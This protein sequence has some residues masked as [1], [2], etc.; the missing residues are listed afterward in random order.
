MDAFAKERLVNVLEA[1]HVHRQQRLISRRRTHP[2]SFID[3]QHIATA[4][5]S[6]CVVAPQ[7]TRHRIGS[8]KRRPTSSFYEP[9]R[10]SIRTSTS[11][12]CVYSHLNIFAT[13]TRPRFSFATTLPPCPP[14]FASARRHRPPQCAQRK[15]R[16]Q[17]RA[18]KPRQRRLLS[19]KS[20]TP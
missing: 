8:G 17:L 5:Y 14:N 16:P 11:Q 9:S 1:A 10:N 13:L 20:K 7:V 3:I 6:L 18:R 2:F 15:R 19:N 4:Y 12:Y